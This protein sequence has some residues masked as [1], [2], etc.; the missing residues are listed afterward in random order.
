MDAGLAFYTSHTLGPDR[1][2]AYTTEYRSTG[3]VGDLVTFFRHGKP[4]AIAVQ[5]VFATKEA[6]V[7]DCISQ[8]RRHRE[9][10]TRQIDETI[11]SLEKGVSP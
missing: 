6:A 10:I 1:V 2:Y 8:L 3:T 4:G 5:D 7:A 11:A 9:A